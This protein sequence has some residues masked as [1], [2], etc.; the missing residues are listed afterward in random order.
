MHSKAGADPG[1]G[2][3]GPIPLPPPPPS[4][5]LPPLPA[6][7]I[8]Y[9]SQ[10]IRAVSA[11]SEQ[12]FEHV[13]YALHM[14]IIISC[15]LPPHVDVRSLSS[16]FLIRPCKGYTTWSVYFSLCMFKGFLASLTV[17]WLRINSGSTEKK[18]A[19]EFHSRVTTACSMANF[20]TKLL[21]TVY[22][23]KCPYVLDLNSFSD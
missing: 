3:A 23:V 19:L 1:G 15:L 17:T 16:N 4:L 21:C 6:Y 14:H 7:I 10:G 11:S 9:I 12:R 20:I 5:P 22:N 8:R 2:D 13:N 18:T